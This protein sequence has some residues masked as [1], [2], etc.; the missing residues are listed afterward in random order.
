MAEVYVEKIDFDFPLPPDPDIVVELGRRIGKGAPYFLLSACCRAR[1]F[2][3][4]DG[5]DMVI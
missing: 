4:D 5:P 1:G 3:L 2:G